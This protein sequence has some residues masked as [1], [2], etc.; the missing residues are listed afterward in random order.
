[1]AKFRNFWPGAVNF[2]TVISDSWRRKMTVDS[3]KVKIFLELKYLLPLK[4]IRIKQFH[5]DMMDSNK[6]NDSVCVQI[7]LYSDRISLI[8]YRMYQRYCI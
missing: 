1:M 6:K 2:W 4:Q 8:N 3:L 7:I 5:S